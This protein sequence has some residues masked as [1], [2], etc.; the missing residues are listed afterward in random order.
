MTRKIESA[1]ALPG[2]VENYKDLDNV[3]L[4]ESVFTEDDFNRLFPLYNTIYT[5]QGFLQAV[6][7][8]PKFCG[9]SNLKDYS[10]EQACK[11]ELSTLF[12]HAA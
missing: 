8:F 6:G 1:M 7:K 4:V 10:E 12:A 9:E 2:N 11:K 5:Y 3:K